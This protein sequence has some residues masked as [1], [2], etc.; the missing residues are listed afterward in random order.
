[1]TKTESIELCSGE[2]VSLEI[3]IYMQTGGICLLYHIIKDIGESI[4]YI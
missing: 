4:I 2:D 1:V 3:L